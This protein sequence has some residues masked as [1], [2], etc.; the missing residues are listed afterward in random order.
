MT[1]TFESRSDSSTLGKLFPAARLRNWS[2]TTFRFT[3]RVAGVRAS[4]PPAEFEH[5]AIW[6]R[7]SADPSHTSREVV[8]DQ[9]LSGRCQAKHA[10]GI[11]TL[12]MGGIEIV[13]W[14]D[15]PNRSWP[16]FNQLEKYRHRRTRWNVRPEPPIRESPPTLG[17]RQ[18]KVDP[19]LRGG[20]GSCHG[21]TR[22]L[23]VNQVLP[24]AL[25]PRVIQNP[26]AHIVR[27]HRSGMASLPRREDC[28][29]IRDTLLDRPRRT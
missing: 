8:S 7:R 21:V 6:G 12:N 23:W 14:F 15:V 2:E 10:S 27:V 19:T 9:F 26:L 13:E 28:C 11:R 25:S 3:K 20:N 5:A 16:V 22:L 4:R 29:S 1:G 17:D 24:I 18:E